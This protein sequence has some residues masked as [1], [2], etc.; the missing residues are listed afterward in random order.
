MLQLK[1][2][3]HRDAGLVQIGIELT[4]ERMQ[5]VRLLPLSH[6]YCQECGLQLLFGRHSLNT[7]RYLH[8]KQGMESPY[9]ITGE[10]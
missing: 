6:G 9:T 5:A 1:F 2:G 7:Q 10:M 8:R 4:G 3:T